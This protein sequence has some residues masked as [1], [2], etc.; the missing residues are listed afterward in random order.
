MVWTEFLGAE[1]PGADVA[2]AVGYGCAGAQRLVAADDHVW[3][4]CEAALR[5][6][7]ERLRC[8]ERQ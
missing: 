8:A 4:W 2:P 6:E 3:L 5:S 1:I 7:A